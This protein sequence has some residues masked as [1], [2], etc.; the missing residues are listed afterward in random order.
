[1]SEPRRRRLPLLH[2]L[3]LAGLVALIAAELGARLVDSTAGR[4]TSFYLP[5][6]D[7]HLQYVRTHPFIG[8]EWRP[9][10]VREGDLEKGGQVYHINSLGMR[11]PEMAP[12]KPAGVYRILCLG[13]STTFGSGA[14]EDHLTY[15]ARLEHYLNERAPVGVRYEV[16]NCGVNGYT[17]V[18]NL[19]YLELRLVELD[20]DAIVLY[21]GINDARMIQA[22]GFRPDYAH[23]RRSWVVTEITPLD[24]WLLGHVRLYAWATRGLDPENQLDSLGFR[25]FVP[26]WEQL[27]EPDSAGVPEERLAVFFRNL[28]HMLLVAR[29]HGI[30]PVLSTIATC[31]EQRRAEQ[32]PGATLAAINARLPA[33]AAEQGV[34]L[35]DVAGALDGRCELFDDWIHLNDEG[36]D[37]HGRVI[38]DAAQALGLF[39]L[40]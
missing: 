36:S 8:F 7:E 10:A 31:D 5:P 17:T 35:L 18:E 16:G 4:D 21:E 15:P 23:Y 20:P 33:F 22:R 32:D 38:A 28:E 39:D 25:T 2:K 3:L 26:G 19:I 30:E 37:A 40:Q 24:R 11:G 6:A 13:G 14:S 12:E 1:M 34:A 29:A 9:G 27:H